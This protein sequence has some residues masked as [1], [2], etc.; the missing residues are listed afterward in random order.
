[1]PTD[2]LDYPGS[3]LG[4]AVMVTEFETAIYWI[5]QDSKS[6]ETLAGLKGLLL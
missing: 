5:W 3:I 2:H 4:K 1:L 6:P